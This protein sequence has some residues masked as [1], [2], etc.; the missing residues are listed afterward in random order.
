[1]S[2][3]VGVAGPWSAWLPVPALRRRCQILVGAARSGGSWL[4]GPYGPGASAGSV[5]GRRRC[6][7]A[8]EWG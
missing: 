3:L 5:M 4:Q 6:W 7:L 2:S 8:G 1:M